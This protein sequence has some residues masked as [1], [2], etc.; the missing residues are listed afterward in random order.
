ML[1]PMNA[2]VFF[3]QTQYIASKCTQ[4]NP[5]E[6]SAQSMGNQY[7]VLSVQRGGRII[8]VQEM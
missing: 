7:G 6:S 4:L 5:Y 2:I 8:P 3:G 1:M